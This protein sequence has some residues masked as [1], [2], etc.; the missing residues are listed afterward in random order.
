MTRRT[1]IS[2]TAASS[3]ALGLNVDAGE[4]RGAEAGLAGEVGIT[5]GSFMAHLRAQPALMGTLLLHLPQRMRDE[6][7]LRVIDVLSKTMPSFEPA[8]LDRL[9]QRAADAGCVITN[10]KMNQ[11]ELDL[12]DANPEVR[13]AALGSHRQAIDAAHRLG[14]RWVRPTLRGPRPD[15]NVLVASLRELID[16]AAPKDLSLLLE[17][18]WWLQDDPAAIPEILARVGPGIAAAPDTGNWTDRAR[19]E[20]LRQ[21]FPAAVTCDFKAFQL[22]PRDE[23]PRYDL[24]RCFDI[25]WAAGFR[26]PWCLE[27]FND[28]LEG[29]WRGFG[30]LRDLLQGWMKS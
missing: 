19:Y 6:L 4:G 24:K 20:G 1:F 18:Q 10:L 13:R 12:A 29:L 30:R 16:Y 21:S 2:T 25:G 22:G 14:C 23:H 15:F 11:T 26:G 9:R 8:Y 3:L 5:T 17:N 28:S 27:H 7:G